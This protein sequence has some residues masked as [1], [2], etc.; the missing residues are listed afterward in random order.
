M[1]GDSQ[2]DGAAA[3]VFQ[4][5]RRLARRFQEKSVRSGCMT[6]Q[7]P[8]LPVLDDRVLA[9]VGEVAAYQG[10]MVMA[11]GL[12]DAADPLERGLVANVAAERVA[13]V[14]RVD[15]DAARA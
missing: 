2:P 5:A 3:F 12:A 8:V 11:V 9:D 7:Q 1:I 4:S 13:R 14:R 15:D 6:A 10:E